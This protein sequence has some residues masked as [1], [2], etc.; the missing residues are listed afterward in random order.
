MRF[1]LNQLIYKIGVWLI[2]Q[3]Y[4]NKTESDSQ[5]QYNRTLESNAAWNEL[6]NT[7]ELLSKEKHKTFLL[8]SSQQRIIEEFKNGR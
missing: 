6:K 2:S 5:E 3:S 1:K 7:R 8:T 4:V